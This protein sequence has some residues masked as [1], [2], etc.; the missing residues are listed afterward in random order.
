MTYQPNY[1]PGAYPARGRAVV[2]PPPPSPWWRRWRARVNSWV[3]AAG[4]LAT[5]VTAVLTLYNT[6]DAQETAAFTAVTA[7]G[8]VPF[9][10]Y[11]QRWRAPQPAAQSLHEL[12]LVAVTPP[13]P[14][15]PTAPTGAGVFTGGT[16][17]G[18]STVGPSTVGPSTSEPSTSEQ[19]T[20]GPGTS[21]PSEA[22]ASGS[23]PG[24]APGEAGTSGQQPKPEPVKALQ[25]TLLPPLFDR[26]AG[27][28]APPL[29][30][31]L[32]PSPPLNPGT[33]AYIQVVPHPGDA[34]PCPGGMS[35][36]VCY[37]LDVAHPEA[38][39]P[40]GGQHGSGTAGDATRAATAA[41]KSELRGLRTVKVSG[42]G[43]AT[44]EAVGVVVSVDVDLGGLR[45]KPVLLS[46]QM[47]QVGTGK[48]LFG[49]WLNEHLAYELTADTDHDT[50]GGDFW[51][52]LPAAKG[53]YF[54]R[55]W[56]TQNDVP[57][58]TIDSPPVH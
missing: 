7:T 11:R 15:P 20:G 55:A 35:H 18:P 40:G 41:R 6:R 4:A 30:G 3:L 10:E 58:A 2:P 9:G 50:T 38:L 45:G 36:G 14:G 25:R 49:D 27:A 19:A 44:R 17:S 5:A 39:P 28:V 37:Y 29:L 51:I 12:R 48:R 42:K 8:G 57:L 16:T 34:G 31:F 47:W 43:P 1:G 33:T 53:T 22:S 52:P 13:L 21:D 56:L 46:W 54:I 26:V 24:E 23:A 32:A